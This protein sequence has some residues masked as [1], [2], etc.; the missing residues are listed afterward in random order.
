MTTSVTIKCN[1]PGRINVNELEPIEGRERLVS[2][3]TLN[4]GS[5]KTFNVWGIHRYLRVSETNDV[6][7]PP[8]RLTSLPAPA[9]AATEGVKP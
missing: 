2:S 9:S 3:R 8:E 1:G 5:E 7:T 6:D 4:V